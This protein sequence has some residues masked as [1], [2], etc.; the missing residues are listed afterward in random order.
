[1][2]TKIRAMKTQHII[3][4]FLVTLLII[5]GCRKITVTT[6]INTD[7]SFT[8]TIKVTG[9]S[10]DVF[11]PDLP[12]PVDG[13]WTKKA[14]KDTS[15]KGDYILTYTK[16]FK[17]SDQL[18]DDLSQDTSWM[19]HLE[20]KFTI[21][22]HF[23]FFYSYVTFCETYKAIKPFEKLNY[24]NKLTL[25]E[26]LYLSGNRTRITREDSIMHK[27]MSDRFDELLIEA[28]AN[29]IITTMENGIKSLNDPQLN[30]EDVEFYRD[31]IEYKLDDYF[32]D[33]NVYID[34]YREWTGNESVNNLKNLDPPV[35]K[36]LDKK[37]SFL[38]NAMWM[39]GYSQTVEMPG[40]ITETNSIS[41]TGNKVS[42]K[43]NG[44]KFLFQDYEM[45]VESRVVNKWAFIV[46][47]LL[48]FLLLILLVV[49]VR[50]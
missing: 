24:P 30:P 8:R 15:D 32:E 1:M 3:Y 31:S 12:Y 17:D 46:S 7:G 26:M 21:D 19:K 36:E 10:S 11:R 25:E 33:M 9:D 29:E 2:T 50:K 14:I 22:K 5:S 35:F 34:F 47:G 49:K 18:N 27:Q 4:L 37:V 45:K 38:L 13:T 44:N 43:V 48:L 40:L 39:E 16:T 41:V 6:K 42:W 23:G 28:V 20:R